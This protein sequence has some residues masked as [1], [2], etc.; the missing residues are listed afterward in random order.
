VQ[1]AIAQDGAEGTPKERR[2]NAEGTQKERKEGT[3]HMNDG[4]D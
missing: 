1:Q 3:Q 4:L 2:R